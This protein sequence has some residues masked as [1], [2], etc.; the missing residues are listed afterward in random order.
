MNFF[1][2]RPLASIENIS[3]LIHES[4]YCGIKNIKYGGIE[5]NNDLRFKKD[6]EDELGFEREK[7]TE[8]R[9]AIERE[10]DTKDGPSIEPE[11]GP[12]IEL[13]ED[14][15]IISESDDT[16]KNTDNYQHEH[17]SPICIEIYHEKTFGTWKESMIH[18]SIP[19]TVNVNAYKSKGP[20]NETIIKLTLMHPEHN[21]QLIS[22]NASFA[23]SYQK[24][25]T[26]MKELIESYII[27]NI[28]VSSQQTIEA[29]GVQPR[30]FMIDAD[31]GL[32]K[33]FEEYWKQL[34][35]DFPESTEYLLRQ[36]DSQVVDNGPIEFEYDF[37]QIRFDK[38][39]EGVDYSLVA[40]SEKAYFHISLIPR[41][42]Y[43]DEFMD[44]VVAD[45]LFVRNKSLEKNSSIPSLLSF[46]D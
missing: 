17:L 29:T 1:A 33:T 37:C 43:K 44:M 38:L 2:R 26:D 5:S 34:M 39:L 36:L 20:D 15:D 4:S 9:P 35:I 31:L 24:L 14:I 41:C 25:T 30:A 28:D 22:E 19:G 45:E 3:P 11:D 10:K 8:D 13:E 42:W 12:G 18:D 27:C 46:P 6:I 40:E 16:S 7:D 21:H 23:T 32:K